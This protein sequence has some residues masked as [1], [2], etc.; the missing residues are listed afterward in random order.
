MDGPLVGLIDAKGIGDQCGTTYCSMS[1][2]FLSCVYRILLFEIAVL[3]MDDEEMI[4]EIMS[5]PHT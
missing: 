2:I 1:S 5:I 4:K 3:S